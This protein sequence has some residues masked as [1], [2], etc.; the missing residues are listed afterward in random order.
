M[1][2]GF[3]GSDVGLGYVGNPVLAIQRDLRRIKENYP[4]IPE[5]TDTLGIYEKTTASSAVRSGES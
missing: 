2:E 4:A 1:T 5:I 3:P